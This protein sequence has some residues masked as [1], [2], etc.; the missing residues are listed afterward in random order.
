MDHE[1]FKTTV[2]VTFGGNHLEQEEVI[3][4]LFL[5]MVSC[6]FLCSDIS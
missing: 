5:V 6:I 4:K 2:C 3:S 1:I